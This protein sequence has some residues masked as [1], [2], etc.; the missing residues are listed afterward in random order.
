MGEKL[1]IFTLPAE[2]TAESE[3]ETDVIARRL[4][5]MLE[6]ND[7]VTLEGAMGAGKTRFVRGLA[8]ALG[9]DVRLVS[10]PTFVLL[11]IY[12]TPAGS[13]LSGVF[14]LDAYRVSG[15]E[16]LEAIGFSELLSAGGVVVL[17][18]PSKVAGL[19]E[20]RGDKREG[21]LVRVEIE[22]VSESSR[23]FRIWREV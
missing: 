6:P 20:P 12:P 1:S 10:S 5:A 17:E 9:V 22:P 4:A 13:R 16:E 18:W 7:V 21:G 14:H 8:A 3:A 19:I 2:V 15:A 11:N 23:R